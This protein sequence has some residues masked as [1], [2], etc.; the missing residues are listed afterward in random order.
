MQRDRDRDINFTKYAKYAKEAKYAKYAK[1]TNYVKY[2]KYAK[3]A[4]YADWLKQ[5]TPGFVVHLAMFKLLK[6]QTIEIPPTHMFIFFCKILLCKIILLG[7][8]CTHQGSRNSS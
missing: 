4:E 3:Y 1:Y 2:T 5:S 8:R 6:K 7:G